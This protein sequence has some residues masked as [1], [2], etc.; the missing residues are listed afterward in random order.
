MW[1]AN[2]SRF[3]PMTDPRSCPR[4][5]YEVWGVRLG[6]ASRLRHCGISFFLDGNLSF[7]VVQMAIATLHLHNFIH[8]RPEQSSDFEPPTFHYLYP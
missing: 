8:N 7:Q 2:A 4:C 5:C 6:S 1:R 3:I